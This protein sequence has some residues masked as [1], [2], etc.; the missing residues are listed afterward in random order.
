MIR[1]NMS[2]VTEEIPETTGKI[3]GVIN[4][5]GSIPGRHNINIGRFQ[6][7]R[8]ADRA[9]CVVNIDTPA[10]EKILEEPKSLPNIISARQVHR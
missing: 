3:Q 1:D 7:G 9:L 10:D 4:N 5:V 6:S 8:R 2:P